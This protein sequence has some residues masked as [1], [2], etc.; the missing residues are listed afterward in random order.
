MELEEAQKFVMTSH[1]DIW[2]SGWPANGYS[3]KTD[4]N[5]PGS[6]LLLL[7]NSEKLRTAVTEVLTIQEKPPSPV[8]S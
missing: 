8:E 4:E 6:G 7:A 3:L 5:T 2:F 1:L